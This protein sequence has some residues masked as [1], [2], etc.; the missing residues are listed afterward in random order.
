MQV[1]DLIDNVPPNYQLM[2]HTVEVAIDTLRANVII[3]WTDGWT[4]DFPRHLNVKQCQAYYDQ[5]GGG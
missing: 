2:G 5:Y 4:F 1:E 3:L